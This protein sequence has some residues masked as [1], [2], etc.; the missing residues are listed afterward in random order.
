MPGLSSDALGSGTGRAG[1]A[2]VST[3][4]GNLA[5]LDNRDTRS[6]TALA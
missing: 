4:Q 5:N 1:A 3:T 6:Q 2:L